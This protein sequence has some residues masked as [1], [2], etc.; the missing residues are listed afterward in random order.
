MTDKNLV[1][2]TVRA[3]KKKVSTE[4]NDYKKKIEAMELKM[5]EIL[6]N[7]EALE[8]IVRSLGTNNRR[9]P[10]VNND[11]RLL[12][13]I[14][15]SASFTYGVIH[16]VCGNWICN[17]CNTKRSKDQTDTCYFCREKVGKIITVRF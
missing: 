6:Q 11:E 15:C 4:M 17:N 16:E 5:S 10:Q 12:C 13:K 8:S 2:E 9:S 1:I 7:S 14:C 3:S